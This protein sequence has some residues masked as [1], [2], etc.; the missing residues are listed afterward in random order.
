MKR[1]TILLVGLALVFASHPAFA[2]K[3]KEKWSHPNEHAYQYANEDPRF[4]QYENLKKGKSDVEKARE[5][6]EKEADAR[7]KKAQ[8]ELEKGKRKKQKEAD[9]A[10]KKT[11]KKKRKVRGKIGTN[12]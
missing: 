11:D 12:D 5:K 7:K 2:K 4:Q 9:K 10:Q 6:E 1:M 8:K 3:D